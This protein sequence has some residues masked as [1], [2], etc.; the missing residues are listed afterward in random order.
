MC[1]VMCLLCVKSFLVFLDLVM[2]FAIPTFELVWPLVRPI[3]ISCIENYISRQLTYSTLAKVD[4][5]SSLLRPIDFPSLLFITSV[6]LYATVSN[7]PA[8]AS[9]KITHT[10][11]MEL[12]P[13]AGRADDLYSSGWHVLF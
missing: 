13:L 8:I 4:G 5:H 1:K 11:F 2:L 7:H 9:H 3:S 10:G 12:G 6:L